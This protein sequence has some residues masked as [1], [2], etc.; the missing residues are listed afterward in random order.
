MTLTRRH[1]L[2]AAAAVC[3]GGCALFGRDETA[4]PRELRPMRAPLIIGH[5]GASGERPEHTMMAYRLAID[6]GADCIEPDLVP[7]KDGV[8]VCRHENDISGT[9]NVADHP[10]FASRRTSKTVD[11]VAITGWFTED[12]TLAELKTLRCKERLPQLR[13]ANTAYDG[14]E[15]IV[16][17]EEVLDL[18]LAESR[19]LG[20]TIGVV[21][22]IK[23]ATYFDRLGLSHDAPLLKA[24]RDRGHTTADAPI[25]IESFETDNLRRIGGQTAVRRVQL[26]APAG[27]PFNNPALSYADMITDTGLTRIQTYAQAIGVEKTMLLPRDAGGRSTAPTDLIDR[28][29]ESGLKVFAWTFRAENTFLPLELR[30]GDAPG[31][32][33]DMA[34][35]LR[36]LFARGLDGAFC[37]FPAIGV[38]ARGGR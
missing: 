15:P 21:P 11:G 8:L 26:V 19:R 3:A 23:H 24:L 17:F 20:R 25:W 31:A 9:T 22:E 27:V 13:P 14:Q 32:H 18:A 5:R 35:E 6:E 36:Q 10:E 29:H 1:A 33:G 38:A 34:S 7:S 4:K 28:A 30:N 37:D 12:F 16:T 2:G